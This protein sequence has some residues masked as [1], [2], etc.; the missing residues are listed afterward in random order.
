[1][2]KNLVNKAWTC[3]CGAFNSATLKICGNCKE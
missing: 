3:D 2:I 1:M